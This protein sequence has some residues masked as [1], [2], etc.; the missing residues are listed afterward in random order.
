MRAGAPA[1]VGD[2]R[3]SAGREYCT[4]S[5]DA[6]LPRRPVDDGVAVVSR[7]TRVGAGGEEQ[8]G[9]VFLEARARRI[10]A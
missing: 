7:R 3:V 8:L 9:C 10:P 4:D 5:R 1:V 6:P 2:V